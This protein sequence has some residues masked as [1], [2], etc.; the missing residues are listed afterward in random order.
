MWMCMASGVR[1]R[2][3]IVLAYFGSSAVLSSD[4]KGTVVP[5][6]RASSATMTVD[7]NVR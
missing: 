6:G 7:E 4:R 2:G 1:K 5:V 3:H